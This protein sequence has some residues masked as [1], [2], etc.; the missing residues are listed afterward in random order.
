MGSERC[1]ACRAADASKAICAKEVSKLEGDAFAL[2]GSKPRRA[3]DMTARGSANS[4]NANPSRNFL[5]ASVFNNFLRVCS[6]RS[7]D[8]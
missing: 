4:P 8:Q 3:T 5:I 7:L 1:G 6:E 2:I